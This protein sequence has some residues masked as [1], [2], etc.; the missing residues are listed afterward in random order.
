[1]AFVTDYG[2]QAGE[3]LIKVNQGVVIE[4]R[5]VAPAEVMCK[6]VGGG[7]IHTQG[8][9]RIYNPLSR[10]NIRTEYN[11]PVLKP[12]G[13]MINSEYRQGTSLVPGTNVGFHSQKYGCGSADVVV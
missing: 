5:L 8:G 3:G 7:R 6:F 12:G 11:L 10:V 1:M 4:R 2:F 13:V 9:V